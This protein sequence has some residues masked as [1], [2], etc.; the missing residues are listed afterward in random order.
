MIEKISSLTFK[1]SDDVVLSGKQFDAKKPQ[2]LILLFL[3]LG[4]NADSK[5]IEYFAKELAK[6]DISTIVFS[7][8]GHGKSKG[9][10]LFEKNVSDIVEL[11]KKYVQFAKKKKLSFAVVGHS[12]GGRSLLCADISSDVIFLNPTLY[13]G[14]PKYASFFGIRRLYLLWW[15]WFVFKKISVTHFG[16]VYFNSKTF[17]NLIR[18][19]REDDFPTKKLSGN[20]LLL[21]TSKDVVAR[22]HLIPI[23]EKVKLLLRKR[24]MKF[25][26]KLFLGLDHEFSDAYHTFMR[27]DKIDEIAVSIKRF[28]KLQEK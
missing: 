19:M 23:R 6:Q 13:R 12:I 2:S 8:R 16:D 10:F 26:S 4:G 24:Y 25:Y 14:H 9:M 5:S 7:A 18:T 28:L 15:N 11:E 22:Y 27:T 1:T 20:C 21:I 17:K 3:G